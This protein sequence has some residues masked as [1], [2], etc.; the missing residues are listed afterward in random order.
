MLAERSFGWALVNTFF[1]VAGTLF[2]WHQKYE[3]Y[4][5]MFSPYTVSVTF[6]G[7]AAQRFVWFCVTE[8]ILFQ[9]MTLSWFWKRKCRRWMKIFHKFLFKLGNSLMITEEQRFL[10]AWKSWR[11]PWTPVGRD[12]WWRWWSW[13][14]RWRSCWW[15][16]NM[17]LAISCFPLIYKS[18]AE[19]HSQGF[20]F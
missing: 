7:S 3:L 18:H 13:R 1:L 17:H 14:T 2:S 10:P 12:R 9:Y 15:R 20:I 19:N 5:V 6:L 11:S 8:Q 16:R 4:Y